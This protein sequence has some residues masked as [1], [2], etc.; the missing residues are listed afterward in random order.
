[1]QDRRCIL[2]PS[3]AG[4]FVLGRV[5]H[6]VQ[7]R[8][9]MNPVYLA[10]YLVNQFG[11]VPGGVTPMKL[12]KLLYY[13]KAWSLV[14]GEDLVAGT[15]A[16]W[17]H[18]PVNRDVYAHFKGYG[19]GPIQPVT[20]APDQKPTGDAREFV[21]FIGNS[22]A[23]FPAIALSKMTHE[24]APWLETPTMQTI[25]SA[26]M[27]SFYAGQ[28]FAQNLPFDPVGKPYIPIQGH[29]DR[30]FTFDMSA[31]DKAR[32]STYASYQDYLARIEK[33][34]YIA[35]DDWLSGLLA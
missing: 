20:L 12:Q 23:R 28:P 13:V 17:K 26:L 15:F 21:H 7:A 25:S 5:S 18:G 14:D 31:G 27:E 6:A 11:H 29:M 1:M 19:R 22:Y 33:A 4:A 34:G 35:E 10:Q 32:A 30:A 24:E 16:R 2:T 9:S 3:A 8:T